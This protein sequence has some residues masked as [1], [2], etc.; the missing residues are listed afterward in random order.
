[1]A[2]QLLHPI[3][4]LASLIW[5]TFVVTASGCMEISSAK[6]ADTDDAIAKKAIG[7]SKWLPVW[8]PKDAVDIQEAHDVDTNES[9]LVF[10]PRSGHMELPDFCDRVD[11]P[12]MTEKHV[13]QRF[14]EFSRSA[15]SRASNY[16][17]NFYLCPEK[18]TERWV[19]Y[20]EDLRLVYSRVKF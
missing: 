20:D 13:M 15:W 12:E 7:E 4:F 10:R 19:M 6:Y 3:G 17:G 1:M 11:K 18:N 14:P 16:N 9:W 2:R 8:L 5:A